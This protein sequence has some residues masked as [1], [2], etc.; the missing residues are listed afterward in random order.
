MSWNLV[1]V[2]VLESFEIL[3]FRASD[4][5]FRLFRLFRGCSLDRASRLLGPTR[6]RTAK[7]AIARTDS[8]RCRIVVS[9][10]RM[11]SGSSMCRMALAF[12]AGGVT[13]E[14]ALESAKVPLD[15]DACVH[16]GLMVL[17][18]TT[19]DIAFL[20]RVHRSHHP[21]IVKHLQ[22]R[23]FQPPHGRSCPIGFPAL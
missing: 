1:V 22:V 23:F 10:S 14:T 11:F 2:G 13:I 15:D 9:I 7:N 18:R 3:L 20:V 8:I 19:T 17:G 4:C 12:T 16:G 6:I 21:T 5:R